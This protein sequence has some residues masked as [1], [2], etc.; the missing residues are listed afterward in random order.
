[1]TAVPP[2]LTM[3][4]THRTPL[5]QPG[6]TGDEDAGIAILAVHRLDVERDQYF[7]SV[8]PVTRTGAESD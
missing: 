5:L 8:A 4:I 3:T 1:M 2:K 7:N 6:P